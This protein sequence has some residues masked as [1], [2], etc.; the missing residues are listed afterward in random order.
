MQEFQNINLIYLPACDLI[1]QKALCRL[2]SSILHTDIHHLE[3]YVWRGLRLF[4][5]A[6]RD[7]SLCLKNNTP[8][9]DLI[10]D[11]SHINFIKLTFFAIALSI[12]V[13]NTLIENQNFEAIHIDKCFLPDSYS[14]YNAVAA[15]LCKSGK[16]SM[17]LTADGHFNRLLKIVPTNP[18]PLNIAAHNA[19]QLAHEYESPDNMF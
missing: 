16:E 10:S 13:V 11:L 3:D 17:I 4:D 5:Y 14:A 6:R 12:E 1:E 19:Q 18:H 9:L 15:R 7:I 8:N 2:H